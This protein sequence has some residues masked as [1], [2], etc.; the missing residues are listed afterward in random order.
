M[1]RKH[2]IYSKKKAKARKWWYSLTPEQQETQIKK[3]QSKKAESRAKMPERVQKY[4]E[5][6]PWATEGV[7]AGNREQWLLCIFGKNLWLGT[8]G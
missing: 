3:W 4:D 2:K 1:K 5:K 8:K 7:N 6:Y